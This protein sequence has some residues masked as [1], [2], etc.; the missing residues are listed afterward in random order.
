MG[1]GRPLLPRKISFSSECNLIIQ[2]TAA[3]CAIDVNTGNEFKKKVE[4]INLESCSSIVNNIKVRGIGGKIIIDFMPT[5]SENRS[6]ITERLIEMFSSDPILTKIH[7][8]TK[9]N[10][11]EIE[12]ERSKLPLSFLKLREQ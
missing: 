10:N 7:G 3:F 1:S 5:N 9:G 2:Q 6:R 11:F 4:D 8:W 12:R